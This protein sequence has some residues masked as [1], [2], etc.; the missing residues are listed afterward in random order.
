MNFNL[1]EIEGLFTGQV[2]WFNRKRGFGFI[3]IIDSKNTDNT[4]V[5]KDVFVHQKNIKPK[6]STYRTLEDNEYV[7]LGLSLDDKNVTHAVNVTGI[8]NGTLI[9][10]AYAEKQNYINSNNENENNNENNN[11]NSNSYFYQ[12]NP[13]N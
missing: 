7:E 4:F 5:G 2:K 9:C 12:G 1:K 6:K 10:D 3:K 8:M 11:L 13:D